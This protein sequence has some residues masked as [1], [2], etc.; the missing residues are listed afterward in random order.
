[1]M[2][3]IL[4]WSV[5]LVVVILVVVVIGGSFYM[6]DYSLSPDPNRTDTAFCFREQFKN[7]PETRP[8]VDSLRRVGALRDT[9]VTMA[10]GECL[11]ALFVRRGSQKTAI[12]VHGWRDCSIDFLYLARLYERELGY[13]V[14]MPDLHAHGL[15]EGDMIQMG[16]LDRQ[17]VLQWLTIFQTDTMVVHGVS[18]GGATTM[19][20]SAMQLPEGV[21]DIRYVDDC[22]YTSVWDEFAGELRN[23][24][25]LPEFP[26]MFTTSLLCKLRYGWSFGEASAIGEVRRSLRP[27]L[28]IHG[29]KDTFVPTEMGRRLY[30]AKARAMSRASKKELWITEGA[31]HAESYKK[32][33]AEYIRRVRRFVVDRR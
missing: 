29:N 4:V 8:W 11:H 20:M 31:E 9:F 13:N 18:M 22:G 12:V 7:Y 21:K 23:Q 16:W 17:D 32:H 24:F 14:V 10:S 27:I 2:K 19:M 26:L 6:L 28:F 33:K 25:D 30:A 3:K 15:S 5:M 1:M